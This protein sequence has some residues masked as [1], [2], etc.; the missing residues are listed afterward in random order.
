MN[1]MTRL[2]TPEMNMLQQEVDPFFYADRLTMPK[3]VVNA[4][5]DEFQQ[6]DDTDYWWNQMPEPKHFLMTPNA[7]HSEAT[8][9][10]EIVPAIG[11]WLTYLLK[12]HTVPEFT[13]TISNET[14][15][16]T[17]VL[18]DVGDVYEASVWYAYSCGN[19]PDGVKRRDFRIL[20]LDVP[21]E[22]GIGYDGYCSNL[23][24]FSTREILEPTI[25]ADGKRSYTAHVEAPDD[26]RWVAYFIDVKYKEYGDDLANK[27]DAPP[28]WEACNLLPCDKPGRLEFTTQVSVWPNTFPYDACTG[29][30]CAGKLL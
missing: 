16:I 21:C 6:P 24:S 19:N 10:F 27:V 1:I 5:L 28:S 8:G 7:E 29:E 22:C 25:T 18:D 30:G 3:L 11:T 4:V 13:W 9:I 20:S 14:G 15:A 17:A 2:D 26:G 12:K 23:K